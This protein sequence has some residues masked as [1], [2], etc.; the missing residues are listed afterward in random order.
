MF[1][2]PRGVWAIWSRGE[3][4]TTNSQ[5]SSAAIRHDH[6]YSNSMQR[7]FLHNV[8]VSWCR[9]GGLLTRIS[10]ASEHKVLGGDSA[11]G[12]VQEPVHQGRIS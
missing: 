1:D 4:A 8:M 7:N 12:L 5:M 9:G 10:Q 6:V 11:A 2:E 3:A